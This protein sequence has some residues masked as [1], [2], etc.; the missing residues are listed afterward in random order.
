MWSNLAVP[1]ERETPSPSEPTRAGL[2]FP[3]S[4]RRIIPA[5]SLSLKL[6]RDRTLARSSSRAMSIAE[7][8]LRLLVSIE[9]TAT[10]IKQG[11]VVTRRSL[12]IV[13]P[14]PRRARKASEEPLPAKPQNVLQSCCPKQGQSRGECGRP[15]RQGAAFLR[16]IDWW[17][18]MVGP[19]YQ[20][21]LVILVSLLAARLIGPGTWSP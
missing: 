20:H 14:T 6:L 9:Y 4:D 15:S 19:S 3:G 8:P 16:P 5:A 17:P 10:L 13:E 1:T 11:C 21:V 18:H 2:L 7:P 12:D